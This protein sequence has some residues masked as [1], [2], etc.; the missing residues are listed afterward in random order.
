MIEETD[1]ISQGLFKLGQ[2]NVLKESDRATEQL[3][4][5]LNDLIETDRNSIDLY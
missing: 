3:H 5:F 1:E 4:V 2:W